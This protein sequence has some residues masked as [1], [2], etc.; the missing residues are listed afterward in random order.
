[1]KSAYLNISKQKKGIDLMYLNKTRAVPFSQE[2]PIE[3][4]NKRYY[5]PARYSLKKKTSTELSA[6]VKSEDC[7]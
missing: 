4:K 7:V 5:T 2:K 1:M 3:K 6:H